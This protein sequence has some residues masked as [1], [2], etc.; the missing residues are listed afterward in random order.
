MV[1][2]LHLGTKHDRK[3]ISTPARSTEGAVAKHKNTSSKDSYS[4]QAQLLKLSFATFVDMCGVTET[5]VNFQSYRFS[6]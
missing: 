5:V 1:T 6:S 2:S 4:F 3:N